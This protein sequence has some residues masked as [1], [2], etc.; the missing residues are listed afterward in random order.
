MFPNLNNT[1]AQLMV[2]CMSLSMQAS[3][4]MMTLLSKVNDATDILGHPDVG[5]TLETSGENLLKVDLHYDFANVNARLTLTIAVK[6]NSYGKG[7]A[8]ETTKS[9]SGS[10]A[11]SKLTQKVMEADLEELADLVSDYRAKSP[12]SRW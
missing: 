3:N 7:Y 8:V 6:A 1:T 9:V 11:S 4:S 2:S 10:G 5:P 12:S